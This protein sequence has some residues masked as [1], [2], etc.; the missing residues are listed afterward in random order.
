MGDFRDDTI[1]IV[2]KGS[3]ERLVYLNDACL[4]ALRRYK[5]VRTSLPNLVDKDALFVSKRTGKRLSARRIEQIVARCLQSAGL[6][7]RGFSPHKLRHTAATLMY[8]HGGVDIRALK[9]I[10]GHA[11]IGTTEIY[12][13][14]SNQMIEQ[15]AN[16]SPLSTVKRRMNEQELLLRQLEQDQTSQAEENPSSDGHNEPS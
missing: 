13:H 14:I 7:G 2:G 12:T 3:K 11:N 15:A 16:A 8:Q 6:S 10:L 1:R 4:D 5:K 9:E